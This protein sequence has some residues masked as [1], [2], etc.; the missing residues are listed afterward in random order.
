MIT[1]GVHDP[2][3]DKIA[4][5]LS[6]WDSVPSAVKQNLS[7]QKQSD[8]K[9]FSENVRDL[10]LRAPSS[11]ASFDGSQAHHLA[12]ESNFFLGECLNL[13]KKTSDLI[14]EDGKYGSLDKKIVEFL[15]CWNDLPADYKNSLPPFKLANLDSMATYVEKLHYQIISNEELE[16]STVDNLEWGMNIHIDRC[17]ELEAHRILGLSGGL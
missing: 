1:N 17:N 10:H 4:E 14:V 6:C 2:L 9:K 7:D 16:K 13:D 3:D 5:F 15:T 11:Y 12:L 8:F